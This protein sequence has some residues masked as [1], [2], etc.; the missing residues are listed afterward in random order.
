MET[1]VIMSRELFNR[2]IRQK[3]KS[4]YFCASDLVNAGNA[5]RIAQGKKLF[6][7]S[8][9]LKNPTT[10]DFIKALEADIKGK[11]IIKGKL[12]NSLSWIHPFLFIDLALAISPEL[13]IETY[14]WLYDNLLKYRNQSGDSYKKMCG[15][16]FL[17]Q[18]NKS[19][20]QDE[21]KK[22]ANRIKVE[23]NVIDWEH[24]TEE[25]LTLRN[26]I[27]DN[28]ALLSDIIKDRETLYNV[29]IKK[30]KEDK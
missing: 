25:Q 20:Y 1:E 26:K 29:A 13:K 12:K 30:A 7:Y 24:A 10:Q 3:S 19:I 15:A 4:E 11:A 23:C 16:L 21:L 9:W 8:Q 6:N 14:K 22:L 5:W 28:I 18:S 27:H 17:T 2:E